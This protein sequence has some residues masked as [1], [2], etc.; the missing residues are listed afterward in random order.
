MIKRL[1]HGCFLISLRA[2][3]EAVAYSVCHAS[4]TG[5]SDRLLHLGH[6]VSNA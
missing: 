3:L 1:S 2:I 4:A 6:C 5:V